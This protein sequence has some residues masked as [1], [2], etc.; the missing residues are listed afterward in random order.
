MAYLESF[1]NSR[2]GN[3]GLLDKYSW[4][5]VYDKNE[6]IPYVAIAHSSGDSLYGLNSDQDQNL[7]EEPFFIFS[8][9]DKIITFKSIEG[10]TNI[11]TY[12]QKEVI[13]GFETVKNRYI[14]TNSL[15]DTLRNYTL[16]LSRGI[17]FIRIDHYFKRGKDIPSF[18]NYRLELTGHN[19]PQ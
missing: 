11:T 19:I 16:Y 15:N 9:K 8:N 6:L 13:N 5:N 18:L 17:G 14:V 1:G 4:F 3:R 12:A 10:T 2:Y 7:V